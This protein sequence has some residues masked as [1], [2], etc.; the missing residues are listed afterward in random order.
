MK[1]TTLILTRHGETIE[2][3]QNILVGQMPG[4]L[5]DT[6]IMQAHKLSELIE[7][8]NIDIIICSDLKRSYDTADIVAKKHNIRVISTP[9]LR[10]MDWGIYTG[11]TLDDIDWFNLP[12]SVETIESTYQ[13]AQLFIQFIK[14]NYSGCN[15]LAV[16]HGAINRVIVAFQENKIA[17]DM[18]KMPIMPNTSLH[19]LNI[20][21]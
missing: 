6:G 4:T 13:R 8:K 20:R 5:S 14:D 21:D 16:G 10:E 17:K 18:V 7:G 15:I 3:R 19:I 12:E 9:L 11:G 1:E 2:N